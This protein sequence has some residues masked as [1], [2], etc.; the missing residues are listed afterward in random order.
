MEAD[1]DKKDEVVSLELVPIPLRVV[2]V[3][4]SKGE[5]SADGVLLVP[6]GIDEEQFRFFAAS[7]QHRVSGAC[8]ARDDEALTALLDS[9]SPARSGV[10]VPAAAM[11]QVKQSGSS[12]KARKQVRFIQLPLEALKLSDDGLRACV[13]LLL[14][15]RNN[16][17]KLRE[18]SC[19]PHRFLAITTI[20]HSKQLER[21]LEES[22]ILSVAGGKLEINKQIWK[23]L[24]GMGRRKKK[25]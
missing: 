3:F 18:V 5:R 6:G 17:R 9:D 15:A 8:K 7:M 24:S 10:V 1:T 22:G 21:E 20:R 25:R 16:I 19:A 12:A 23:R 11:C 13:A 2:D 4:L 14:L